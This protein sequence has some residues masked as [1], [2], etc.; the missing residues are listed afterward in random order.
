MPALNFQQQFAAPVESGQKCQTIRKPRANAIRAGQPLYLYTGM[1]TKACRLLRT[2]TCTSV[3]AVRMTR[4]VVQLAHPD[5]DQ[6]IELAPWEVDEFAE[7]DGF[8][9]VDDFFD[10]FIDEYH[11]ERDCGIYFTGNLIK[12]PKIGAMV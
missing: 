3:I 11:S 9:S 7:A 2:T 1:R 6:W 5:H 12:W 10:F 4:R 8:G